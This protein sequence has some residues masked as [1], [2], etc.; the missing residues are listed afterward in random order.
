MGTKATE[1]LRSAVEDGN[2]STV[3]VLFSSLLLVIDCCGIV[4]TGLVVPIA[5]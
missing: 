4:R 5:S 3:L 2:S 1:Q